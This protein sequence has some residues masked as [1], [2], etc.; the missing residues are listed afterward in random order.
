M[1]ERRERARERRNK[2]RLTKRIEKKKA[3]R[4]SSVRKAKKGEQSC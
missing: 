1:I 3:D 2:K 4:L